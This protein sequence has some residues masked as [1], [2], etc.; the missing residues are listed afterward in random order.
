MGQQTRAGKQR[1]DGKPPS[2][3]QLVGQSGR[4]VRSATQRPLGIGRHGDEHAARRPWDDL[5]DELR[6]DNG[7]APQAMLLPAGDDRPHAR[8][9]GDRRAGRPEREPSARAFQAAANRPCHRRAAPPAER[10]PQSWE[11]GLASRTEVGAAARADDAA[12]R[13]EQIEHSAR[14]GDSS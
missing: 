12:P 6:G 3:R 8:V 2:E 1:L 9:V 10:R 13:Q 7:Q 14:L 11:R 4:G 5:R